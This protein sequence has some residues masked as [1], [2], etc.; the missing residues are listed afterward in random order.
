MTLELFQPLLPFI[1]SIFGIV[2]TGLIGLA[3][4]SWQENAKRETER[5][6]RRQ[7]LYE[8]LNGA[9]FGLILAATSDDR[10]RILADIEKGWLFASDDVLSALFQYMDIFDTHWARSNG[11]MLRLI[12]EDETAR[13]AIE[14][15]MSKIFLAMRRDLRSTQISEALAQKYM[16]FYRCG[17]LNN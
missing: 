15:G 9:L 14:T 1:G 17:M 11:E 8:E 16:H 6:Q 4:Y 13:S 2:A 3:T 5:V 12:K 10:R 7:A